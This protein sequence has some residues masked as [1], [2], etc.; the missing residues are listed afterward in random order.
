MDIDEIVQKIGLKLLELGATNV[1]LLEI[2]SKSK[3]AKRLVVC[4]ASNNQNVKKVAYDIKDT[5]KNEITC[6]HTD[7]IFKGDWV[8]LDFKDILVN[9]FTKETRAKFN[10][11]K[12]YKD[13]KNT[14]VMSNKK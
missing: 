14:I 3:V 13:A 2:E 9:I 8:V 5:F 4:T 12:L 11:E 6:L 1:Q 7:G 10:I